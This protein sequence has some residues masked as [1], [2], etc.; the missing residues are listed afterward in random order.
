M[1]AGERGVTMARSFNYI[2]GFTSQDDA[3]PERFFEP[4]R[5]G[6]LKGHAIDRQKFYEAVALYYGMMGWDE[7]GC[8]TRAKLE[9][10]GVG[11][12]WEKQV[13]QGMGEKV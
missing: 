7:N 4:M 5:A 11:W 12:I 9:E 8:P 1:K 13:Q 2:H 6:T 10:L 3:L